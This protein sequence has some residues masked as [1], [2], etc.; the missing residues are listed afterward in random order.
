MTRHR[1]YAGGIATILSAALVFTGMTPALAEETPTPTPTITAPAENA[2]AEETPVAEETAAATTEATASP[3]PTTTVPVTEPRASDT[4]VLRVP[5]ATGNNA[6]ITVKVGSDRVGVTGVTELAGVT[7]HLNGGNNNGS[8]GNRPDGV[9]ANGDGWAKC[10]SDADGDCSFVVPNTQNGGANRDDRYWVVQYSV[11]SSYY[12]NPDLRVGSAFGGGSSLAYEFRTGDELRAGQTYESTNSNDFMASSGSASDASGGIWQQSRSNPTLDPACG[13]DVALILDISGSVGDALPDLKTAANTFVDAL[14]GTPSRMSLFSFSWQTPGAGASANYPD[15][16]SVSTGAQATTFKNRYSSWTSGG[17]TNWDRGLGIAASSNTTDNHY[18][19]AVVITDGNPTTYNQ[20]PYQGSGSNNR[21]RETENGVF[22]A[23]A[24][25]AAGT[26]VLA[27]GV[28]DGAVGATNAL[29]LRAISGTTAFSGSNG[30]TADYYQTTNYETVG[31]ALRALAL[32]NCKGN[33]AVTKQIVPSTAAAGSI[34]GATPAGAGWTFGSTVSPSTVTTP[35]ASRTTTADGTGTVTFPLTF[36]GGVNSAAVSATETQQTGFTLQQVNGK[37][38]VC[39]NRSTGASVAVTNSGALGFT[40]NVP[41]TDLVSCTV[42]NRAPNPEADLTVTK[43]WVVNGTE[44]ANGAQPAGLSAQLSLTGPDDASATTQG[45]GV[46]RSGY[47][48]GDEAT[49]SESVTLIDN[50]LCTNTAEVTSVNG[51]ATKT[52]LGSGFEMELTKANNTATITNTVECRSTLTLAKEVQGGD[53][54]ADLWT[55]NATGENG[56]IAFASGVSGVKHDVTPT[57]RY[58]L[59]E[60]GGDPRY[61]QTDNRTSL[62]SNPLSTGSATCIRVSGDGTPITGFSDGINGGVNVPLGYN[63]RCTLVNQTAELTLLKRVVNDNGGDAVPADWE[64]TA[65]PATLPGLTATSVDGSLD[66]VEAS[67]F[68]VRPDHAYTLTESD[69]SGYDFQKLEQFVDGS[70][71]DVVAVAA[72]GYPRKNDAGNWMVTV[73]ALDDPIY[74]FVNDDIAPTLTLQ[75][76]VDNTN[77]GVATA[78]QWTLVAAGGGETPIDGEGAL[79]EPESDIAAISA[80]VE[81]GVVYTLSETDGPSG[82]TTD[83]NWACAPT[84]VMPM[85]QPDAMALT[86]VTNTVTLQ[87]GDDITCQIVNVAEDADGT[88]VKELADGYPQQVGNTWVTRYDITVT[89]T[90]EFS[91]FTYELRD[92]LDFG[93]GIDIDDASVIESPD[94]VTLNSDWDGTADTVLVATAALPAATGTHDYT[95]EVVSSFTDPSATFISDETWMC[96]DAVNMERPDQGGFL[97]IAEL[98]TPG[99]N[100]PD[101]EAWACG[102]PAF[103]MI[104]KTAN[105]TTQNADGSWNISYEITIAN[106]SEATDIAAALTDQ[107]PTLPGGWTLSDGVWTVAPIDGAPITNS[108]SS[109]DPIWEGT[110]GKGASYSYTVSGII[111]PSL[112]ADE[113]GSC[114]DEGGLLNQATVVSGQITLSDSA[115]VTVELPELEVEKSDGTVA[116]LADGTWQIDYEITVTNGTNLASTYTL[117]DLPDLGTGFTWEEAAS[118]WRDPADVDTEVSAP[119]ANTAIEANGED[120]YVYRVIASFDTETADPELACDESNGG[121]FFNTASIAFPGG[122]DADSGCAEPA[123]PEVQKTA[124][125]TSQTDDGRWILTYE[126]TVMNASD[127]QLAY[128]ATDTIAQLPMGVD[129][130]DW[131]ATG[132]EITGGTAADAGVVNDAWNGDSNT[133]LATGLIT[134]GASHTYT[135]TS[136]VDVAVSASRDEL[137]CGESPDSATGVWNATTVTNGVGDDEADAC[138]SIETPTVSVEKS[139]TSTIQNEDGTWTVSY[140]VAV[141]NDSSTLIALYDLSDQLRFG[142]GITLLDDPAASWTGPSGTSGTFMGV[143][144]VLATGSVLN[145]GATETYTVTATAEISTD[146]WMS[147]NSQLTCEEQ[148]SLTAGGFL[149]AA[150]VFAGGTSSTADDCSTPDLPTIV[151]APLGATQVEGNPDQ[152]VVSYM[153]TVTPSSYDTYYSLADDPDFA[154]GITIVDASG[155]AVRTDTDP[156]GA[157]I[158]IAPGDTFPSEPVEILAADAPHTWTVS[159]TAAIANEFDENLAECTQEP[160]SGFY[161]TAELLQGGQVIDESATC[162]PVADRVYPTVTKTVSGLAQDA[163]TGKWEIT[164]DLVVELAPEGEMNPDGLSASYDLVD[165]L[166]FGG[167]IVI[168]SASWALGGGSATDFD[169]GSWSAQL[170]EGKAIGPGATHTYTVSAVADVTVEAIEAGTTVCYPDSDDPAGGF[171][172]IA[173]LTSG[174]AEPVMVDACAEPVFPEIYKIGSTSTQN[175]NGSW[176]ISYDV[177]VSYPQTDADPLPSPVGFTLTDEPVLPAG[178]TLADGASWTAAAT[179]GGPLDN[180]TWNGEGTWTLV[181]AGELIV[182]GDQF[183]SYTYEVSAVVD[184]VTSGEQVLE[185]CGDVYEHGIVIWNDATVTSGAYED[186]DDGCTVVHVDDVGIVKTSE[187]PEGET[188]VAPGDVFDYVLTVTNYGTR[189]AYGLQVTD[190]DLNDRLEIVGLDVEG[191]GWSPS[192]GYEGNVVD[193]TLDALGVGESA[194]ITLTVEFLPYEVASPLPY[195][196]HGEATPTVPTPL[197]SLDNTACVQLTG[198]VEDEQF[199]GPDNNES[200]NC[201]DENIPTRDVVASVYTSCLNDAALLGWTVSKSELLVSE[202]IDFVWMPTNGD[203]TPETSPSQ[204]AMTQPGGTAT[205][206]DE[207]PWPGAEF[208]PAG[209]SIDYPGWRAI[210]R[211]DLAGDGQYY[212]PGTTTIMTP[213][214]QAQN[215][216]NGLILDPSELDF[217]WRGLTTGTFSVNPEV[218]FTTEYPTATPECAVARHTEV[219]VDKTASVDKS[220]PG[221]SFTYDIAVANV[222]TDSAAEGVVVTDSIPADLK[223]TDVSWPG[224]DDDTTFPYWETCEVSGADSAGY[225]GSLECVLTGPLQPLGSDNG[226]PTTAPT[227]TLTALVNASSTASVITNVAVVDY[228]T[229]GDPEDS[230]RDSDDAI[231]LLSALPVT[232]G[233]PLAA[234]VMLGLLAVFGGGVTVLVIR[235]RRNAKL[236]L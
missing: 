164:Y 180:A 25:K 8:N 12:S 138:I 90:S 188:S 216:F 176:N 43:K 203:V 121:A 9:S 160:G 15:L 107:W 69:V 126:V 46:A 77:G 147:E 81:A 14:A 47:T 115:C 49:L 6:V 224:E 17:G 231:V 102:E 158:A 28:G 34:A 42:Y 30:S 20:D 48:Q 200:N 196:I 175:E 212:L 156:V 110:L 118:S 66:V 103:P 104:E 105:A 93:V 117:T 23:N 134:A 214:E 16:V 19:V 56:A 21:F 32:G 94:G 76:R 154:A 116:Q 161:N 41:S 135:V 193:L 26:R 11:P 165:T 139:V 223:I 61:T 39:T 206:S 159:F 95:I 235:R 91:T 205:W 227:I 109:A 150:T 97:N 233:G 152:W 29:N 155:T 213:E 192:P 218:T 82:Y 73:D 168:E 178:V 211:S 130:A 54:D 5:D 99:G 3:R 96:I 230:G 143:N 210:E 122:T 209:I 140:D 98:Y 173:V 169:S 120:T 45:W 186:T 182:D 7:L 201:D 185:T 127:T 13:L 187:L 71:T 40:V 123:S 166:D 59:F 181:E 219:E 100:E 92:V 146:A 53:A 170:A 50:A 144:A 33:L 124:L 217:A 22:S 220:E 204:V 108:D 36:P 67:T 24:L 167:D 163:T 229:F 222:S 225:G 207:I 74:R 106:E 35:E 2:V 1:W 84:R 4:G 112:S 128:S 27:F 199:N 75:K 133:E 232:G 172:N 111:T 151:K 145:G 194:T 70:W 68:G 119:A 189:T 60:T 215:V 162:I 51:V 153:I 184:V 137:A 58:Q 38:A 149:N 191:A 72:P 52:A 202:P 131:S 141:T 113:I 18:D 44:Y 234:I 88:I 221:E 86:A 183:P 63:V 62:Q 226:G 198:Q 197:E 79:I 101:G 55:L 228:Y 80:E 78:D 142:G 89:N 132:P 148:G 190:D 37:N 10:V 171:L 64:L 208:N 195:V 114:S 157:P 83:N 125:A 57:A 236:L 129:G 31:N 179:D 174:G 85:A 65:T 136:E 87:P 177:T